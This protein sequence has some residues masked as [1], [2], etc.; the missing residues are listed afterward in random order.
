MKSYI[1][2][3]ELEYDEEDGL[4]SAVVPALAGCA[5]DAATKEEALEAIHEAA[6][7]YIEVLIEDGRQV[8]LTE[9]ETVL[10]G[11]AVGKSRSGTL[12]RS[13]RYA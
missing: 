9:S 12:Q 8:P 2:R 1:Y 6:Q 13:S 3:V 10:N 4:W 7:A 11:A 5:A